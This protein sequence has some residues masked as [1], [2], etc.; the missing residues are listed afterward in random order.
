M[1]HS[2]PALADLVDCAS[3]R[4]CCFRIVLIWSSAAGGTFI[5]RP[6]RLHHTH[7]HE[8]HLRTSDIP[9]PANTHRPLPS[10]AASGLGGAGPIEAIST[11]ELLL[12]WLT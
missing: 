10:S 12:S 3:G 6:G 5:L 11:A 2:L 4:L 9:P 7:P 8:M 1:R